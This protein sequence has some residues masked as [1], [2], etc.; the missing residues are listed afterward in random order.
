MKRF[1]MNFFRLNLADLNRYELQLMLV[2]VKTPASTNALIKVTKYVTWPSA[3]T[4]YMKLTI[5]GQLPG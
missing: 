3:G 4:T 1:C 2:L 5:H